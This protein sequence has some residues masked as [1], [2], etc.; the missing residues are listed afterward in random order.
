MIAGVIRDWSNRKG[1]ARGAVGPGSATCRYVTRSRRA[2][3]AGN[4]IGHGSGPGLWP[5]R[6]CAG[7]GGG[8]SIDG[9]QTGMGDVTAAG[10]GAVT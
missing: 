7:P 3:G 5:A 10:S 9:G 6:A 2:P 4:V 8:G 1:D